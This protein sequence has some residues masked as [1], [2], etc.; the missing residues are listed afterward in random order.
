MNVIRYLFIIYFLLVILTFFNV[1]NNSLVFFGLVS[2]ILTFL[3]ILIKKDSDIK[4]SGYWLVLAFLLILIPK[5]L[6]YLGNTIPLGYDAGI[7][8]HAIESSLTLDW[9]KA[10]FTPV[11]TFIVKFLHLFF[12]STF[13]LTGWLLFFELLLGFSLFITVKSYFNRNTAILAT[14]LFAVSFVQFKAFTLL[15]YKNI[16]A[17]SFLFLSFY[18]LKKQKYIPFTIFGILL[19]GTH[20]PTF[21][22]F[23]LSFLVY[24]FLNLK[25]NFKKHLASGILILLG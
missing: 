5:L 17:M 7:Y 11:F 21:L 6:P 10:A 4:L 14:L 25:K 19:G 22:L 8:K 12:S 18:F 9:E 24:T 3:F 13:I 16:I 23:A 15:Y 1:W 2:L 20:Q